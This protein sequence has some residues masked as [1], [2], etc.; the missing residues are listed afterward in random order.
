MDKDSYVNMLRVSFSVQTYEH[1]HKLDKL[2]TFSIKNEELL[3][4]E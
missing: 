2:K 4:G 3:F 1:G